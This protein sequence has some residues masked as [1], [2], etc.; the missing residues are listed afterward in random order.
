MTSPDI[1]SVNGVD[2][3]P[4]HVE[5]HRARGPVAGAPLLLV[6]GYTGSS[7][8]WIDV[9]DGLAADRDVLTFDHRGHGHSGRAPDG[10]RLDDMVGD[11][12]A[13]L[14]AV[15]D[16]VAG[17]P[18]HLLGH[19]MGGRIAMRWATADSN[20]QRLA[21]LVLMD[22]SPEPMTGIEMFAPAFAAART[23]GMDAVMAMVEPLMPAGPTLDR[24]RVKFAQ[25]D[26]AAF[27]ELGAELASAPSVLDDL[28]ALRIPTT[29]IVGEHD[30]PFRAPSESMATTI[31]GASLVVI[32]GTAHSPQEERPA[33]WTN[34]VVGHLARA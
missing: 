13:V 29:V 20:Q 15:V 19:S 8:D 5:T 31:P 14:D 22:T 17:P 10:Y 1:T 24:M 6:H 34:T 21:S 33:E 25:M 23:G 11:L 18:I 7:L 3:V 4:L 28:A 26:P 30:T 2:D 12:D 32:A 9:V 27:V 16:A